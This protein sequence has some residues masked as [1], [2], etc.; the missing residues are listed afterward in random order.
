MMEERCAYCNSENIVKRGKRKNK[1]TTLQQYYCKDCK[2]IF[3]FAPLKNKTYS[4]KAVL[5]S[6]SF[7]NQGYSLKMSAKTVNKKYKTSISPQTISNWLKEFKEL[8]TFQ[9]LRKKAL[10]YNKPK[11]MVVR[12]KFHH[13]QQPYLYQY[14]NS[15][16]H[17]LKKYIKLKSYLETIKDNC[18]NHLFENNKRCS[19]T[20][21]NMNPNLK[22]KFNNACKLAA[23]VLPSV[24]DNRKR[25]QTIQDFMLKNDSTTIAT[26]VPV[27]LKYN[28]EIITGHI[29]FLQLRFNKIHI[30]D[31]KPE[32]EKE[33]HA[34]SQVYLYAL[35]LS[36]L[37][38]IPL[39][40]FTCAYFDEKNYLEFSPIIEK[41]K[42]N[43]V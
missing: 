15:K 20:I 14:H 32:A 36:N 21:I 11:D 38:K 29:D 19:E 30:L 37:T 7:Y 9:R 34:I 31:Y 10:E 8:T 4:I 23:L 6:L 13:N 22:S 35:A 41:F 18:P 3:T 39:K 42:T 33:K 26:E 1:Y 28:N 16:I 25:H 5:D 43:L 27:Y 40:C 17:F 24:F 2:K 12:R